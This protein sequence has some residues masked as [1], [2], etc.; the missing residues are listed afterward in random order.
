MKKIVIIASALAF[1][2]LPTFAQKEH[3]KKSKKVAPAPA[4][5]YL[6]KSGIVVMEGNTKGSRTTTTLYFD[7]YGTKEMTETIG[8]MSGVPINSRII[9]AGGFTYNL[10]LEKNTGTKQPTAGPSSGIDFSKINEQM[11]T[12]L[13]LT[14]SG[15][16]TILERVCDV[17]IMDMPRMKMK[18][19]YYVWKNIPLK[20]E[21]EV[22]GLTV[23]MHV[24]AIEENPKLP[25]STFEPPVS[26]E[27]EERK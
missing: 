13:G 18:G 22:N 2:F 20:S 12:N 11:M 17:W 15:T 24:A 14:K 10:D 6:L 26:M 1:A 25:A 4:G 5:K 9:N 16:D 3:P 7:D 8:E 19:K 21:V 27:I 23:E